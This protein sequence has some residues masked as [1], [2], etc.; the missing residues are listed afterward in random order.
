VVA[1][2]AGRVDEGDVAV[3]DAGSIQA[4][5]NQLA[6]ALLADDPIVP[7]GDEKGDPVSWPH[8]LLERRTSD[9]LS[10]RPVDELYRRSQGWELRRLDR[11]ADVSGGKIDR[12]RSAFPFER[13]RGH[14]GPP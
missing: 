13:P 9:R 11:P 1:V 8:Q 5:E 3:G 4:I 14:G 6:D 10:Q 7:V 12:E 2:E